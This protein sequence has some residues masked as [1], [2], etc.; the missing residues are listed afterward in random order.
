[1]QRFA[2]TLLERAD[3]HGRLLYGSDYPLPGINFLTRTGLLARRGYL[4][5]EERG[6]LDEIYRLNPLVF[7]FVL[8]RTLRH[9][10]TGQRFPAGMFTAPEP[11]RAALQFPAG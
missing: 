8:K 5:G 4:S 9:P 2:D 3:L 1:V 11:L 6:W 7:D 10:V